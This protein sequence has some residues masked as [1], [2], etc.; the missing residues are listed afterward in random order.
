MNAFVLF[1]IE[2][3]S[4]SIPFPLALFAIQC[5]GF[6]NL[7][8]AL[9]FHLSIFIFLAGHIPNTF[10]SLDLFDELVDI[11]G[12]P[13]CINPTDARLFFLFWCSLWRLRHVLCF[14]KRLAIHGKTTIQQQQNQKTIQQQQ[15]TR[16]KTAEK[17]KTRDTRRKRVHASTILAANI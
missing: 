2:R 4:K 1:Y 5:K 10:A 12:R 17:T 13:I 7:D 16:K 9:V 6:A 14:K 11:F 3:R 15:K 8:P